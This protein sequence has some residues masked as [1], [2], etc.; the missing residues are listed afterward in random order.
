MSKLAVDI[1]NK[2]YSSISEID[3]SSKKYT[4]EKVPASGNL[5][6]LD[7]GC[8]T[9]VNATYFRDMGHEVFGID[10]SDVAISKFMQNGF[11]GCV[12]NVADGI[13][14]DDGLFDIVYASD[15]I[16]HI[17][18]VDGFLSELYR[19][20]KKNGKL[21]LSTP[22]SA[23]WPYRLTALM[24]KTLTE[25]Q[26]PGHVRFFSKKSLCKKI[27]DNGFK[28]IEMS[29]RHIYLILCGRF[30]SFLGPFLERIGMTNEM[31]FTTMRPF[32]HF[33]KY[34]AKA[35][36]FWSDTFIVTAKK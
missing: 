12:C 31:R 27:K 16:E 5:K 24:G 9:G 34:S 13:P 1:S 20:L 35:N 2:K 6:I 23:F 3:R 36:P 22:N 19:V 17:D 21:V 25:V 26:H 32:W 8:G 10:I 11:D 7:V 18:N 30:V 29:S 15:V 33:S 14:K 4:R 28:E